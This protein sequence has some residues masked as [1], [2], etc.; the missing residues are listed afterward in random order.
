MVR[1]AFEPVGQPRNESFLLVGAQL[2]GFGQAV[3][4]AG[5]R[6][7][8]RIVQ[9]FQNFIELHR[10]RREFLQVV[11]RQLRGGF[12]DRTEEVEEGEAVVHEFEDRRTQRSFRFVVRL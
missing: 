11:L 3:E 2:D 10:E 4:V 12:V 9:Q 1:T 7:V 5:V 8:A 6:R